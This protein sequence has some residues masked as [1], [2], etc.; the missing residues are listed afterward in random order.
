MLKDGFNGEIKVNFEHNHAVNVGEAYS[1]L[2]VS[3]S[4]EDKFYEYYNIGMTPACARTYHQL[5]LVNDKDF[6][7]NFSKLH[8]GDRTISNMYEVLENKIKNYEAQGIEIKINE[9]HKIV[10]VMTPIMR[11]SHTMDFAKEIIFIDS[12][13]SC[14]QTNTVGGIPLG[15]VFHTNQTEENYLSA[16]KVLKELIGSSGFGGQS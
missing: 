11:K 3:Q 8:F 14:D 5:N 2:R 13:R 7:K 9:D 10:A 12:S 16:F 15:I 6:L 1:Y 4:T